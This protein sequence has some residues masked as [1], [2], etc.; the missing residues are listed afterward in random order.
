VDWIHITQYWHHG[1]DFECSNEVSDS[2]NGVEFPDMVAL[3]HSQ[4]CLCSM[5]LV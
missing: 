4:E 3:F 1:Q 2:I 5:E